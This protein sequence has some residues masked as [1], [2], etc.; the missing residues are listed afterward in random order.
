MDVRHDDSDLERLETD[1]EYTRGLE[2]P[3]VR[4]F[5]K[6]LLIVRGVRNE[7][8]LYQWRSLRFEKLK[9]KRDHQR[10]LR[11]ND[12]WRV[13]VEIVKGADGNTVV[14]KGIEDYH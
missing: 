7:T 12:Q 13:V 11:L 6:V 1:P 14:V 8:E 10:S 3:L 5:R 4:A 9:G 2:K